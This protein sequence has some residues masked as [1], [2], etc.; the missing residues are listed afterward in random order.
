MA[1]VNNIEP[2]IPAGSEPDEVCYSGRLRTG[3]ILEVLGRFIAIA[4]EG[5]I[6]L[7]CFTCRREAARAIYLHSVRAT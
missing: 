7:G 4:A 1:A 3:E 5:E 2:A 6:V